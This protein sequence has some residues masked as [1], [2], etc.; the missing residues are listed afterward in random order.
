MKG[1][2]TNVIAYLPFCILIISSFNIT[3]FSQTLSNYEINIDM[4][5]TKRMTYDEMM[6]LIQSSESYGFDSQDTL[7]FR[8]VLLPDSVCGNFVISRIIR[9]KDNYI[10][11]EGKLK[12]Q[13]LFIYEAIGPLRSSYEVRHIRIISQKENSINNVK[14]KKNN[15]YE[16]VLYSISRT[17]CCSHSD[18]DGNIIYM[19]RKPEEHKQSL[20]YKKSI[21]ISRMD[22]SS[23]NYFESP[24]IIGR[25]YYAP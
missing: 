18:N 12:K 1:R 20:L 4:A 25:C 11:Q 15:Q 24:N 19:I 16:L 5:V 9:K 22:L 6:R 17:D 10:V 8:N 2:P 23:Y 14:I 7:G 21:W 13:T 3:S